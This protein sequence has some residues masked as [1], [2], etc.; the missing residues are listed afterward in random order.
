MAEKQISD[1]ARQCKERSPNRTHGFTT[2]EKA[3]PIYSAWKRIKASCGNPNSPDYH[4]YGGRGISVCQRWLDSFENFLA[5]M[6]PKPSPKHSIDRWPNKNGNYEPSNCRWATAKEQANNT[7][8]N[9]IIEFNGK[10]QTMAQ[11]AEE[12]G[13]RLGTL[14]FRIK[15][16]WTIRDAL[17]APLNP[18]NLE[19]NG[20][21]RTMS[22]LAREHGMNPSTLHFRL[23][24]GWALK[25]AL[26][27]PVS[28]SSQ[29]R[30]QH[31]IDSPAN[32]D[33]G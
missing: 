19:F 16:G 12:I 33:N 23:R 4:R 6:G 3:I 21:R 18:K 1:W 29:I 26:T 2:E 28:L 14:H 17:S 15:A 5:D 24:K 22:E 9:V 8:A 25:D 27:T 13:I 10:Q 32:E 7:R 11:W 30:H 31:P 20:T